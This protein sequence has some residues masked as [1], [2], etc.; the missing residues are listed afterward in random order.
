MT[1]LAPTDYH[2]EQQRYF[3]MLFSAHA[4]CSLAVAVAC[5]PLLWITIG[6]ADEGSGGTIGIFLVSMPA[7]LWLWLARRAAQ[8]AYQP[9]LTAIA[10][11]LY[12]ISTLCLVGLLVAVRRLDHETAFA[13]LAVSNAVAALPMTVS[14]IG[15]RPAGTP[16][17]EWTGVLKRHWQFGRW[18]LLSGLCLN[19]ATQIPVLGLAGMGRA[20]SAGAFRA[21]QALVSPVPL[22]MSAAMAQITPKVAYYLRTGDIARADEAARYLTVSMTVVAVA[23]GLVLTVFSTPLEHLAYADKYR[24][25]GWLTGP[26]ALCAVITA[27]SL[28]PFVSMRAAC[29]PQCAAIITVAMLAIGAIGIPAIHAFGLAGAALVALATNAA[30]SGTT[31]LLFRYFRRQRNPAGA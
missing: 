16:R 20:D 21:I 30:A 11:I 24:D 25:S 18:D 31:I 7:M 19:V 3:R 13:A 6:G 1:V 28:G 15:R 2:G 12:A 5:L 26:L 22:I 14:V 10:A 4:P 29:W 17:L 9:W 23:Y 8:I 27:L